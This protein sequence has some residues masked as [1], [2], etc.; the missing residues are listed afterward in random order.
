RLPHMAAW[1]VARLEM[2]LPD[3]RPMELLDGTPGKGRC[4]LWV[5][6]P[7]G[8]EATS[9]ALAIVGDYVPFGIG[10]A[11]GRPTWS[12]SLDN[13]L[14]VAAAHPTEWVLADVRVHAVR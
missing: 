5:R 8:L 6:L 1:I 2:R 7:R 9:A 4:S 13:T 12:N 3:A 11:R 14:R 10:Q